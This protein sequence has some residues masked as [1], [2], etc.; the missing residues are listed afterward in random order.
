ISYTYNDKQELISSSTA[1][2]KIYCYGYTDGLLTSIYDPKHTEEKPYETTFAYEE[3]KLTEITDPVGK[4][5]TLSYDMEEQQTTL[6]NEKKK[7]TIYS[8][9]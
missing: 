1:R 3:E 7:K 5:T 6:T 4:K 8:Y 9:N 2:G